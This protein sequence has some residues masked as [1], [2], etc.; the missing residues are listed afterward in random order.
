MSILTASWPSLSDVSSGR[1]PQ[2]RLCLSRAMFIRQRDTRTP[3]SLFCSREKDKRKQQETC[4]QTERPQKN[5]TWA[6]WV[7]SFLPITSFVEHEANE[8]KE[9]KEAEVDPPAS[10]YHEAHSEITREISFEVNPHAALIAF[11]IASQ[12]MQ[13]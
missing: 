13:R 1:G 3:F 5:G 7:S 12:G 9:R 2:P 11:V 8:E 10:Q 4:V 6:E